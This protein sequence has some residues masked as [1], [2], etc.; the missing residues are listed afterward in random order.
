MDQ[1]TADNLTMRDVFFIGAQVGSGGY[2]NDCWQVGNGGTY[3]NWDIQRYGCFTAGGH[4]GVQGPIFPGHMTIGKGYIDDGAG[5][6]GLNVQLTSPPIIHD[7]NSFFDEGADGSQFFTADGCI[8]GADNAR[9]ASSNG[10]DQAVL[11]GITPRVCGSAA[12]PIDVAAYSG[13]NVNFKN[14]V[15]TGYSPWGMAV[16][17]GHG[18]GGMQ[19]FA[20]V[21]QVPKILYE[22]N[23]TVNI[24]GNQ[25]TTTGPTSSNVH[26]N[27]GLEYG[28]P[29]TG[30][31]FTYPGLTGGTLFLTAKS[32]GSR[33]C[34]GDNGG[35]VYTLNRAP[36]D[37]SGVTISAVPPV[38]V[39]PLSQQ[40]PI[41]QMNANVAWLHTGTHTYKDGF[42]SSGM[43]F[44]NFGGSSYSPGPPA[45]TLLM[46]V[47]STGTATPAISFLYGD[48]TT[49][50]QTVPQAT[51]ENATD[52]ETIAL[53]CH[54]LMPKPGGPLDNGDGTFASPF[55]LVGGQGQWSDGT[56]IPG[57]N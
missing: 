35:C 5:G 9:V 38:G 11:T 32:A 53:Y 19:N 15:H 21:G 27:A 17:S 3:K 18:T 10:H 33:Y 55:K 31:G 47:Y 44:P 28:Q 51:W 7:P 49:N 22:T 39:P 2:H 56:P 54:F 4:S 36:G 20:Y 8:S 42:T 23:V 1:L 26:Y 30:Y 16:H 24:V 50:L 46:N 29:G 6:P 13:E 45:N 57:C 48:P 40:V 14:I 37:V 34:I 43:Q 52:Q 12:S 41:K 25:M